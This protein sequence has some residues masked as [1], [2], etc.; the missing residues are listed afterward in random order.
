MILSN[1]LGWI[2][3]DIGT[4]TVKLA[5]AVRSADGVRLHQVGRRPAIDALVGRR[6]PRPWRTG[7]IDRRNPRSVECG[8]FAGRSAACL[9]PMNVCE[10]RGLNV[11]QGSDRERRAMIANE[12]AEDWSDAHRPPWNSTTGSLTSIAKRRPSTASTSTSWPSPDPGSP[13]SPTIANKPRSIAGPSTAD[14]PPRRAPSDSPRICAAPRGPWRSTGDSRTSRLSIV[15]YDRAL[16]VRRIPNC[17]FR[18]CLESIQAALGVSL[19]Q[20]QHLVAPK[21]SFRGPRR[22]WPQGDSKQPSPRPLPTPSMA[23]SNKFDERCSSSICN[24]ATCVRPRSGCSAA[25]HRC[26][27]SAPIYRRSSTCRFRFGIFPRPRLPG[28]EPAGDHAYSLRQRDRTF[29]T[30]LE[31]RMKTAINLL[32]PTYRRSR[33]LRRRSIQWGTI[34]CLVLA[35]AWGAR[36]WKL[37]EFYELSQQLEAVAREGRPAQVKLQEITDM[38]QQLRNSSSMK[39]SPRSFSSSD[40]CW[41]SSA[42]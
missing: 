37:R 21:A 27:T 14:R 20:A 19:D 7:P 34:I 12:L 39:T 17:G 30:G 16:Y 1:R 6:R 5:Q 13:A 15:G 36:W 3:V 35:G 24:V 11:P 26:E 25:A 32:P 22:R 40:T 38:R 33:M 10:L 31:G 4:R 41:Q 2:G 18:R 42:S 8:E 23:S 9:L 29:G 28:G